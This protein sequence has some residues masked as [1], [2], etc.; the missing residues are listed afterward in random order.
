MA[1][2]KRTALQ[3]ET[4]HLVAAGKV[5]N[6][7]HGYGAWRIR[8]ANASTVGR[9]RS[10]GLLR[11]S[12]GWGGI[13]ELTDAG[14]TALREDAMTGYCKCGRPAV[15]TGGTCGRW[16]CF[17]P[18]QPTTGDL[19]LRVP[20]D[21]FY[22]IE[23]DENGRRSLAGDRP[24]RV[25]PPGSRFIVM[26]YRA[27]A[28]VQ[29]DAERLKH[30]RDRA[31]AAEE[32][33]SH[34]DIAVEAAEA[35]AEALAERLKAANDAAD[36]IAIEREAWKA[37]AEALER[38][39]DALRLQAECWAMEAKGHKASLHEAYQAVTGATGE[40]GNW[41]GARPIIEA[42]TELRASLSTSEGK[43]EK[44]V[45]LTGGLLAAAKRLVEIADRIQPGAGD[46]DIHEILALLD[47]GSDDAI[48]AITTW[49][50]ALSTLSDTKG[51][52]E[53]EEEKKGG[54]PELPCGDP[55][56]DCHD[57]QHYDE[58]R[59]P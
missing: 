49:E 3:I 16:E 40:P 27:G 4:L 12:D 53:E 33:L 14:R 17:Q 52:V 50:E 39:R 31:E 42:I 43:L 25:V 35:K 11:W 59:K 8:G 47:D 58:G 21:G 51:S 55:Q 5:E 37:K 34:A 23:V 32:V 2:V 10:L 18:V 29:S 56:E 46:Q 1:E 38:E 15:T 20:R 45:S 54:L 22:L 44:I 13:A 7:K 30:W 28:W 57:T 6:A 9:L 36:L 41:N 48:A 24:L 26:E 19:D